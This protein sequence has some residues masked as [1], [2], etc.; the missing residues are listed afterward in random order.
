M[1]KIIFSIL[2]LAAV[3]VSCSSNADMAGV[4]TAAGTSTVSA[5]VA[6]YVAQNYPATKVVS[7]TTTGS[8]ST[9]TLNTGET[10]SFSK[11]GSVIAYSNNSDAGMSADSLVVTDSIRP[12]GH[13]GK[14]HR[15]GHGHGKGAFGPD[16]Q[17]PGDSIKMKPGHPRH[18]ENEIA[19]DSLPATINEYILSNYAGLKV[20]HA[21]IDTIC[22][23]VVT[24]VLVCSPK[25]EPVKLVFDATGVYLFKAERMKYAD[26]PAQVSA[27]VTANYSSYKIMKRAEK[28]T[29]ANASIQ[30]KVFM[31]LTKVHHSVTFNADG[32]IACEK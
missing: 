14:E 23:G 27:I 22:Q 11:A 6:A 18:F 28:F 8:G 7:S 32:T 29:L 30:Y 2:A 16:P 31:E 26:V 13:G 24:E 17:H 15:G 20:I 4:T 25:A 1:K 3:L 5:T 21:E 12:D 10:I 19:V 9:V